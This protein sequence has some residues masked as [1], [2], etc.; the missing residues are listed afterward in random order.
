MVLV[1]S[2]RQGRFGISRSWESTAAAGGGGARR[3]VNDEV[4]R[5]LLIV[6][7]FCIYES[8]EREILRDSGRF[9]C[10]K[11]GFNQIND[12]RFR[13]RFQ[14]LLQSRDDLAE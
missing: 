3:R 10:H 9:P 2:V 4:V 1:V 8:K 6:E 11:L 12:T 14:L 5:R 7:P 13:G